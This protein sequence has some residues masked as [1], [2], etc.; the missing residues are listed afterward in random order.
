MTDATVKYTESHEWVRIEGDQVTIGVTDH[1]QSELGNIVFAELPEVGATLNSGDEAAVLES[2]K[3]AADVYAPIGGEVSA[4]N[5]ALD[6]SPETVNESPE[7]QGWLFKMKIS[8]PEEL[9][10]LLTEEQYQELLNQ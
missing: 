1:A 2:T 8:D 4:V 3:A 7:T 6:S 5:E 9:S 10:K